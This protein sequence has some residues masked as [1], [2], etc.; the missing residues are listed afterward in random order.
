MTTPLFI[1]PNS[2]STKIVLV[3]PPILSQKLQFLFDQN[4]MEDCV[5]ITSYSPQKNP[6]VYQNT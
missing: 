1:R 2:P 4:T 6:V 5:S 3:Q